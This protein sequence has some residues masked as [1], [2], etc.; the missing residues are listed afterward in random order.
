[1][2]GAWGKT[3]KN[4]G[5]WVDRGGAGVKGKSTPKGDMGDF[6]NKV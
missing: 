6:K 5:F 3:S 4:T 2:G 1:M